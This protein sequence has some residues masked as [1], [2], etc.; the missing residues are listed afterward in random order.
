MFN[1]IIIKCGAISLKSISTFL[2]QPTKNLLSNAMRTKIYLSLPSPRPSRSLS[3][4]RNPGDGCQ[5]ADLSRS[6]HFIISLAGQPSPPPPLPDRSPVPT[7]AILGDSGRL[8][9]NHAGGVLQQTLLKQKCFLQ[10]GESC[11]RYIIWQPS[12]S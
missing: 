5:P 7:S 3:G 12:H 11:T 6:P 2:S 10:Q 8:H 4:Y 9:K 1:T